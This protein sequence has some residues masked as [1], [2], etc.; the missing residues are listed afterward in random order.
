MKHDAAN[1]LREEH[2]SLAAV[3]HAMQFL[4]REIR[5]KDRAPDFRLLHAMLYYIREYP[6]RLHHPKED[7]YLF[8][9][10]KR[11]THDADAVIADLEREH[12][13]GE[14]LLNDLTVALSVFEAGAPGGLPRFADEVAKFADFYWSHMQKEEDQVLPV[15]ERV[16]TDE[17]WRGIHAAFAANQDPNFSDDAQDEFRRLF[18]RI[19]NLTPAPVG[20]GPA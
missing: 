3:V 15:A 1:I 7:R 18:T 12:A 17:D 4:V 14:K 9:A 10:L 11:R 13:L 6:E 20:L 8:A 2:R 5:D 16:L 19:V